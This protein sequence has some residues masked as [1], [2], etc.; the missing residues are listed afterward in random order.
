MSGQHNSEIIVITVL[1]I[2]TP[3]DC[4][5]QINDE[6]QDPS[7]DNGTH[8]HGVLHV[9]RAQES[10]RSAVGPINVAVQKTDNL[11]VFASYVL[12]VRVHCQAKPCPK[13]VHLLSR[14]IHV[15]LRDAVL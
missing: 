3:I 13:R 9:H 8:I 4:A 10:V 1:T 2:V 15:A 11:A 12:D 5:G 7:L 6:L 14:N